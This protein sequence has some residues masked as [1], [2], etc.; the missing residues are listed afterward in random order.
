MNKRMSRRTFLRYVAVGAGSTAAT[1]LLAACGA[2][3]TQAPAA[4]QP[5]ASAA[6][7]AIP[8]VASACIKNPG[9][10]GLCQGKGG[11][12][13]IAMSGDASPLDPAIGSGAVTSQYLKGLYEGLW[14]R[15]QSVYNANAA[16]P[17]SGVLAESWQW[18][19]DAMEL[20]VKLRSGVKFHD[21]T[22]WN[23]QA[24]Q[25]NFYRI[26]KPDFQYYYPAGA[27][28]MGYFYR[29]IDDVEVVDDGNI[30]IK[31]NKPFADFIEM[32]CEPCGFGMVTM[33][34]PDAVKKY[35]NEGVGEHPVG[36]GPFT[37]VERTRGERAV[38]APNA[39]YWDSRD[40]YRPH[41][42]RLTYRVIGEPGAM[43]AALL[44]GEVD[45][46]FLY[47]PY[48]DVPMLQSKQFVLANGAYPNFWYLSFN[49]NHPI[50]K[51]V[52][53]RQALNI[54]TN[55][56]QFV[57]DVYNSFGKPW[58]QMAGPSSAAAFPDIDPY[59]YDE[60]KGK[61]LLQEV[62]IT[63]STPIEL[64]YQCTSAAL[65]QSMAQ[66][67]QQSWH[68]FG[69]ELKLDVIEAQT[70]FST[71]GK[72]MPDDVAMNYMGWGMNSDWWLSRCYEDLNVGHV[73]DP[74]I[75]EW[76]KSASSALDVS[77]RVGLYQKVNTRGVE[78]AYHLPVIATLGD[79]LYHPR[80][81]G[82]YHIA[83]YNRDMRRVW[84]EG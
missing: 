23:A 34:S 78:M 51:D 14:E 68:T 44:A 24:A 12:L 81:K 7:T 22:P 61:A 16:P 17:V 38:F 80:V 49:M 21:G 83:D 5:A 18:T 52:R 76:L 15:D 31:F 8:T 65:A 73:A 75:S 42:D 45:M 82:Y 40:L 6:A 60:E 74:D 53:V 13:V 33:V 69:V 43:T 64:T 56:K 67:L 29:S 26:M 2:N 77:E 39:D 32:T 1:S 72:T 19:P 10:A 48:E 84:I 59:P 36:T 58:Y 28:L 27:A 4:T 63:P 35:G 25:F 37:F 57:K 66:W 20:S 70:Y 71:W 46:V 54:L 30:K 79:V 55:R 47:P 41:L 3:V 9:P 62:G 11:S 50:M